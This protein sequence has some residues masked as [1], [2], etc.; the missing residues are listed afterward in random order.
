MYLLKIS[1]KNNK[2]RIS[3]LNLLANCI[4]ARSAFQI[5]S[6]MSVLFVFEIF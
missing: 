3:L 1:T 5:L 6:K 4:S 2:K